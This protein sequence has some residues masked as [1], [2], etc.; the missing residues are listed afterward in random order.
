MGPPAPAQAFTQQEIIICAA[1]AGLGFGAD[2][3]AGIARCVVAVGAAGAAYPCP[4]GSRIRR[5][6]SCSVGGRTMTPTSWPAAPS[7][8]RRDCCAPSPRQRQAPPQIRRPKAAA[9]VVAAP[10]A[11]YLQGAFSGGRRRPSFGSRVSQSARGWLLLQTPCLPPR[12]EGL[13]QAQLL[14]LHHRLLRATVL[15]RLC[16]RGATS[17]GDHEGIKARRSG[18]SGV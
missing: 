4:G 3:A 18:R 1:R 7:T 8:W 17:G 5:N 14:R 13:L 9:A 6:L 15:V 16:S 11:T 2:V 10:A 12:I